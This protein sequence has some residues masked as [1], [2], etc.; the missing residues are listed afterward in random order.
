[1]MK[2]DVVAL[3]V[4]IVLRVRCLVHCRTV[5][6]L[7]SVPELGTCNSFIR[8]RYTYAKCTM[9]DLKR[10]ADPCKGSLA[11][12]C[13]NDVDWKAKLASTHI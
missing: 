2:S 10:K 9:E 1:M 11:Y 5:I 12:S 7:D 13:C 3:V 6:F 8:R 4:T